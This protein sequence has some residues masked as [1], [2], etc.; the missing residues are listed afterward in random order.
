M[1]KDDLVYICNMLGNLSGLPVRLYAGN[2]LQFDF[3]MMP[4]PRD[5]ILLVRSEI[6]AIDRHVGFYISKR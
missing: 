6:T 3:S 2:K 5:P 4:L 1:T